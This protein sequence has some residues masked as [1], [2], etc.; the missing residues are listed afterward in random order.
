[1]YTFDDK[2]MHDFARE[3]F[4]RLFIFSDCNMIC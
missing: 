3:K 2:G 1:M 4:S